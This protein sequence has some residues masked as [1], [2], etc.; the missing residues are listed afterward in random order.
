MKKIFLLIVVC[1]LASCTS[2]FRERII[3]KSRLTG[4][5][6]RLFQETPAWELAKAVQDE[7]VRKINEI[8]SHNPEIVNYQESKYG[9]T[10]LMLTVANQQLV[11]FKALLVNNADVNIHDTFT[12]T[13]AIIDACSSSWYSIKFLKLL[14]LYGADVN[15]VSAGEQRKGKGARK[16]PLIKASESGNLKFVKYLISEGADINYQNELGESALT[17]SIIH[18]KLDVA[19]YLLLNGADCERPLFYRPD[20]PVSSE[21]GDPNDKGEPAYLV[22][23]LRRDFFEFD[24]KNYKYKMKIVDFLKAIGIDYWSEPIPEYT[25]KRI[26]ELHPDNWQEILEKY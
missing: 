23:E 21:N 15:D 22:K 2:L 18:D 12:G 6:Y 26:K 3:D 17:G 9:N 24:T 14:V 20:Y 25:E 13:S 16:T 1:L 8:V 5:D 7:D 4:Y 11:P 19:Y 10:L